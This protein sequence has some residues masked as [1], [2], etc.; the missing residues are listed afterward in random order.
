MPIE[1]IPQK[2]NNQ[3]KKQGSDES[4]TSN[5]EMEMEEE[6]KNNQQ[7]TI[8]REFELEEHIDCLDTVNHWLNAIIVNIR[9]DHIRVHYNGWAAKFDEWI[10]MNSPRIL[11][12][13]IL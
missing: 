4:D 5:S 6:C 7:E 12:Q 2:S 1:E 10:H 8:T 13:C 9:D 3:Q 11:K